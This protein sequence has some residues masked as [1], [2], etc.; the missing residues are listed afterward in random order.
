VARKH[1]L[2]DLCLMSLNKI[3]TLPNIEI[4]GTYLDAGVIV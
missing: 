1:S 2:T 4:Q 3:Y